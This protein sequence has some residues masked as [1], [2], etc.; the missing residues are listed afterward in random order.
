MGGNPFLPSFCNAQK[1]AREECSRLLLETRGI[2]GPLI[3]SRSFF[4]HALRK[5]L[6]QSWLGGDAGFFRELVQRL[7]NSDRVVRARVEELIVAGGRCQDAGG[8][9]RIDLAMELTTLP[10]HCKCWMQ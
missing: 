7:D 6:W 1:R 5:W 9:R 2:D 10:H 8:Q 4:V 3:P